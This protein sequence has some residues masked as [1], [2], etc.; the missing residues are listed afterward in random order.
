MRKFIVFADGTKN[1]LSP[2]TYNE[3]MNLEL[4]TGASD[5]AFDMWKRKN[6]LHEIDDFWDHVV[7]A[8]HIEIEL[9]VRD[10]LFNKVDLEPCSSNWLSYNVIEKEYK[11]PWPRTKLKK[12]MADE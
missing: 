1:E 2:L 11:K 3:F 7:E 5:M 6:D 8:A 9:T 12:S 4:W 10:Y